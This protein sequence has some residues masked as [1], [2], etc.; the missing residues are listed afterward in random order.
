MVGSG[1]SFH[2]LKAFG[3]KRLTHLSEAFDLWLTC[4]DTE[5]FRPRGGATRGCGPARL[6]ALRGKDVR[7][8]RAL[9]LRHALLANCRYDKRAMVM[10][11][12]RG[13]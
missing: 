13:A 1:M 4:S 11:T 3:D 10:L 9:A 8:V 12:N 6:S 2:N 7:V 5:L